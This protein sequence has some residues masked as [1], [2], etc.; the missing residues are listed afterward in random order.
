MSI[1]SLQLRHL[2]LSFLFLLQFI[3]FTWAQASQAP[4]PETITGSVTGTA[5]G[6]DS[7]AVASGSATSGGSLSAS[8]TSSAPTS[9]VSLPSLEPYSQCVSQSLQRAIF[10]AGCENIAP[11]DCYCHASNFTTQ[12]ISYIS[13]GCPGELP[14]AENLAQQ[15]CALATTSTSLSFSVT[16]ISSSGS[17]TSGAPSASNTQPTTTNASDTNGAFSTLDFTASQGA[18]VSLMVTLLGVVAGAYIV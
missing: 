12:L 13:S 18:F 14:Q 4:P 5:I 11:V 10:D 15:F 3:S 17:Q 16:S 9:S 6:T 8:A 7:S 1:I 2:P